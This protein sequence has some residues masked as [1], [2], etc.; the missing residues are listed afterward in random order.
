MLTIYSTQGSPGASTTAMHLAANWATAGREVLL[1][2]ADPAG[3]SLSHNL[4]IQF[5]PGSASF[6]G[7]GLPILSNHLIA[8][9]Q[10]VLFE[11]LHVMPAPASP[12]GARGIFNT[13]AEFSED[14]RTISE[15]EMAVI[16]DGGRMTADTAASALTTGA[17]GVVVVCR[18]NSQL[19]S[20]EHLRDALAASPGGDGPQACAVTVGKSPMDPEEWQDNYGLTFSGSIEMVADMATDLS[21]YLGRSKRKSKKWRASLEQVGEN[22]Y[23]LAQPPV[24]D[25]PRRT[26]P[27]TSPETEPA[28]DA[29]RA[30]AVSHPSAT[31][32][33]AA[34]GEAPPM[35][36]P[37]DFPAYGQ[38]A[39]P[40][41]PAA[42]EPQ[43]SHTQ[44]HHLPAAPEPQPSHTQT[45]HLP[46]AAEPQPSHT[47]THHLPAAAEP[48]PSHTQTHH[49]PAAAEPQPS[50]TQTHHLPAAAEPQPS[51]TQTHHLPAAAEPQPS[52]GQTHH[53]PAAAEPQPSHTQT[54]HLPAAAE[55]QPSHTQ[56]HHLPAAAEPQPSHG[57]AHYLPPTG[58]PGDPRS[59]GAPPGHGEA[60]PMAPPE[61]FPAYGQPA[62]P[63]Y[64]PQQYPAQQYP[65]APYPAHHYEQP[66]TYQQP[67]PEAYP[68][69]QYP[70]HHYEQPPA[71]R[72]PA[73]E[74]Y[75]PAP[76]SYEQPQP[77]AYPPQQHPAHADEP[78]QP[79]AYQQPPAQPEPPAHEA[80]RPQ[81]PEAE[82]PPTPNMQP[83][84]SFRDW[85]V[86]LHGSNAQ[87]MTAHR[88]G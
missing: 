40:M 52:H 88:G 27:A 19:P 69:Q 23:P 53:L 36:P 17:T 56:T 85:A 78:P 12:T 61:D 75:P 73:P 4:G 24:S 82:A 28:E 2:E 67:P 81:P 45:H 37:E 10:D 30:A 79:P 84:G 71:Y 41:A 20:L 29:G 34:L 87:D 66:P 14:L 49:L 25:R 1:I 51:H 26:R 13:F 9:A 76:G 33:P 16:I 15:N 38:P 57:Q 68:A 80:A 58:W 46:A 3:G 70:A 74:A 6:V 65:P 18:N 63:P 86:K 60:P 32:D 11:N 31:Q 48:Q 64:P 44:T 83:T 7:S 39:P 35:A 47:Q 62:P 54:H 43:P 55:P 42:P 50:H 8:H 59:P 5:T 22:L 21:A 77:G 72:Q